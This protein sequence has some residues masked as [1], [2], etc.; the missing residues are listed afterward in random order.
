MMIVNIFYVPTIQGEMTILY[1][2]SN[3]LSFQSEL[4]AISL[5]LIKLT[6]LELLLSLL[7][8]RY[9]DETYEDV[10]LQIDDIS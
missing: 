7:L 5:V 9:Y 1:I 6:I 3:R 4:N 10:H 8:E 2:P